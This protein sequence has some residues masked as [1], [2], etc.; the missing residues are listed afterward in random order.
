MKFKPFLSICIPTYKREKKIVN[1][2]SNVKET[3]LN[4][5]FVIYNDGSNNNLKNLIKKKKYNLNIRVFDHLKNRG[6]SSALADCLKLANGNFSL[7]MDS[8]DEFIPGGLNFIYKTLKKNTKKNVNAFL[9]G[10]KYRDKLNKYITNIPPNGKYSS[11]IKLR[12]DYGLKGDMKEVVRTDLLQSCIYKYAYQ[13][14]RTPTSIIWECVSRKTNCL[15]VS[16]AVVIKN[17]S[18]YGL[19]ANIS[20]IKFRNAKPMYDLYKQLYFSN[21]YNSK[22]FRIRSKIQYYRYQFIIKNKIHFRFNDVLYFLI[23]YLFFIIDKI[24]YKY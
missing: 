4:I 17:F 12:A 7:I 20:K 2:L 14:R 19:T 9:F 8:D 10:V 23:A 18:Q 21:L 24:F 22:Y 15:S 1:L 16:K 3:K 11:F 6:R 5:E 13:F